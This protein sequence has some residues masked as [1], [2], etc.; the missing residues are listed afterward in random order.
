MPERDLT[1]AQAIDGF[2]RHLR[3]ERRV[4]PHTSAAYASDLSQLAAFLERRNGQPVRLSQVQKPELRA[5]LGELARDLGSGSIARKLASV[6]TFYRYLRRSEP[7]RDNPTQG[8]ATPRVKRPLPKH[9]NDTPATPST[10]SGRRQGSS[11]ST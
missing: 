4:S 6:R 5:W 11:P 8:L 7:G 1:L 9:R 10:E 3:G 2:V